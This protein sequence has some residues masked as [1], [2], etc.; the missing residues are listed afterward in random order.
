MLIAVYG[1]L[2]KGGSNHKLL[3][4]SAFIGSGCT[5]Y[6]YYMLDLGYFPAIT[7]GNHSIYCEVYDVSPTVLSL[8]DKLEGSPTFYNREPVK[9]SL[10]DSDEVLS[11][12]IYVLQR[13]VS[14][15]LVTNCLAN[16]AIV[17][18]N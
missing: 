11:A 4:D 13:K 5:P 2:K 7:P 16:G 17:W 12:E 1:T 8:L 3:G 15:R 10:E 6:S 18:S 9:I 14:G